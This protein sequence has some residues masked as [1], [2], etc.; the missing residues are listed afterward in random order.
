MDD[1]IIKDLSNSFRLKNK[2]DDTAVKYIKNLV[3]LK[4]WK[5]KVKQLKIDLEILGIF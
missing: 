3:R 5:K 4:K 2:I 1:N